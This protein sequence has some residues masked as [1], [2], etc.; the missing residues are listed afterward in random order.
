MGSKGITYHNKKVIETP[1]TLEIWGYLDET[2][3]YSV[4]TDE[5]KSL[6]DNVDFNE[7]HELESSSNGDNALKLKRMGRY[8]ENQRWHI[9][10]I[11]D[12]NFDDNSKFLTLTFKENV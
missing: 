3:F 1:T 12:C 2:I 7:L 8:Y 11:I 4:G 6:R 10:R 5:N 9:A